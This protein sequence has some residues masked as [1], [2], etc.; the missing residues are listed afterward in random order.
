MSFNPRRKAC[1]QAAPPSGV[2]AWAAWL[3]LLAALSPAARCGLL[4]VIG[5]NGPKSLHGNLPP[6]AARLRQSRRA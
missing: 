5:P 2:G 3:R 1:Q 4:R 6:P